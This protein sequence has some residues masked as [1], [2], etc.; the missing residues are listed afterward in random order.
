MIK[1]YGDITWV[2]K[3]LS[4]DEVKSPRDSRLVVVDSILH[5]LDIAILNLKEENS[6][7]TMR[8]HRDVA[9]ALKAEVALFEGTWQKY[10][11]AKMILF[12][13]KMLQMQRLKI[14][15]SKPEML[16][17]LLL[18]EVFGQSVR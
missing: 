18:I 1:D 10:H 11:R 2:N 15:W 12:L 4:I 14:I 17:K 8:V 9:R 3:V 6:S 5:D 7:A 13:V 16:L